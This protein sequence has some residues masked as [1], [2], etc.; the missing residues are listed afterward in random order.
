MN[1]RGPQ[2]GPN[3]VQWGG[4]FDTEELR[5]TSG[6]RVGLEAAGTADAK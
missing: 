4:A 5:C 6:F 1:P 2:A 3:R